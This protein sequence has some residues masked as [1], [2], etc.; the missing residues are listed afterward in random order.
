MK[1]YY[2]MICTKSWSSKFCR[3]GSAGPVTHT[4][5]GVGQVYFA[6]SNVLTE[7]TYFLLREKTPDVCRKGYQLM[8]VF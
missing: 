3:T 1:N 2:L 4:A 7:H 6:C 8:V 5:K